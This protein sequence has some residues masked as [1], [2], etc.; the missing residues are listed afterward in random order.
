M[1]NLNDY[2]KS[3]QPFE[4]YLKYLHAQDYQGFDDDMS[5]SFDEFLVN[6]DSEEIIEHSNAFSRLLL[7]LTE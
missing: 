5:D 3:K 1:E 2:K 7:D 4:D 6:M